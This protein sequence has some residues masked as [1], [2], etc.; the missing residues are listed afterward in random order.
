MKKLYFLFFLLS[1]GMGVVKAQVWAPGIGTYWYFDAP[2]SPNFCNGYV[3]YDYYKDSLIS[4]NNCQMIRRYRENSCMNGNHAGYLSPIFT[5]TNSNKVVYV[6]DYTSSAS[7]QT[8]LFDTLFWFNAPIGAKWKMLPQSYNCTSTV[9]CIVTVQDTGHRAFQ[10][11]NLRWQ[12]VSYV[13]QNG[14]PGPQTIND[15]I[16]ERFG[17][18]KTEPFN[19]ENFCSTFTDVQTSR[20][21]RCYGDNQISNL[22]YKYTGAC[23]YYYTSIDE[24]NRQDDLSVYPN[25]AGPYIRFAYTNPLWKEASIEICDALGRTMLKQAFA[26]S[27]DISSYAPGVYFVTV[28]NDRGLRS[29]KIIKE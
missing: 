15:T 24:K 9:S 26:T 21:F 11:I 5:Y 18:L 6:N 4:G 28:K 16:Y 8:Q 29:F 12:K 13:A 2:N 19:T 7:V 1:S 17:Y 3:K 10:G 27:L 22:K 23:D 25:P 14:G 20:I